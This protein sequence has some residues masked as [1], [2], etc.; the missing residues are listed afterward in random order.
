MSK[1]TFYICANKHSTC[2]HTLF[3]QYT[4]AIP[5]NPSTGKM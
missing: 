4:F 5:N 2:T 1:R 3:F